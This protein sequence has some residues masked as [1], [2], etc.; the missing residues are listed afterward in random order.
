VSPALEIIVGAL[1]L[2]LPL[3]FAFLD[4]RAFPRLKWIEGGEGPPTWG[5][6]VV[7]VGALLAIL[8][9]IAAPVVGF[10]PTH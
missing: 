3:W 9:A 6:L 1:T 4:R 10:H 2:G 8:I 7:W 5:R